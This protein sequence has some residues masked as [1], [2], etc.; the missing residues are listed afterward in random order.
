MFKL[1]LNGKQYDVISANIYNRPSYTTYNGT[2][3]TSFPSYSLILQIIDADNLWEEYEHKICQEILQQAA[4]YDE[5][6]EAAYILESG[7]RLK[8]ISLNSE[9][10]QHI[11]ELDGDIL[12]NIVLQQNYNLP[13]SKR[14]GFFD[15]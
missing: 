12:G 1:I 3:F 9:S 2:T 15:E 11:L 5:S 10:S 8:Q 7:V 13:K 4:L 14:L 6:V